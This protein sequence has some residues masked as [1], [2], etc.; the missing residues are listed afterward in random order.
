[1]ITT[2]LGYELCWGI[3]NYGTNRYEIE[4]R[5][6]HLVGSYRDKDGFHF[7]FVND[8]MSIFPSDISLT[9]RLNNGFPLRDGLCNIWGFGFEGKTEFN[10]G[11]ILAYTDK[12]LEES[13]NM[14]IMAEFTKGL[15]HPDRLVDNSF[16]TVK[17]EALKD[18]SF[19][20][21]NNTSE[22]EILSFFMFFV[23]L[24]FILSIP[25]MVLSWIR[26]KK[27]KKIEELTEVIS[28]I[29][30]NDNLNINFKLGSLFELCDLQSMICCIIIRLINR[31]SLI[32]I[33]EKNDDLHKDYTFF[34]IK[35]ANP[36][37]QDN[38]Y[39][40][41]IYSILE[42]SVGQDNILSQKKLESYCKRNSDLLQEFFLKEDDKALQI[43]IK[44][45]ILSSTFKR[46]TKGG[47]K[48]LRELFGFK[49]YL[50]NL[51]NIREYNIPN[52]N[53]FGDYM[54]YAVL[55]DIVDKMTEQIKPIYPDSMNRYEDYE[56][57]IQV[58]VRC[59]TFF[60][61]AL[62]KVPLYPSIGGGCSSS[63]SG[64][65]G[66]SGGGTGGGSR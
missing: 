28:K 24:F 64:G 1:M 46:L 20:K 48:A 65:A 18:S 12:P 16:E 61:L 13:E 54:V 38:E 11:E 44:E 47:E 29:P 26:N 55:F 62:S 56:N 60:Y 43:L 34:K 50:L 9:I 25:V 35:I 63:I 15:I 37:L 36:P 14:T 3:T 8:N 6:D 32:P 57:Y 17:K 49:K 21:N 2:D 58:A 42:Q 52:D 22:K 33:Y 30:N 27:F 39:D 53:I 66:Y 4:Y 19:I 5:V 51:P 40:S 45:K 41:F 23:I 7:R 31:G 59:S 10:N